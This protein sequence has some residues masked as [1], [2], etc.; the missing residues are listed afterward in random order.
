M[1]PFY[2]F[3]YDVVKGGTYLWEIRK[4]H[5]IYG[6][7]VRINPNEVHINDPEYYHNI[8]AGGTRRV[9]KDPSTIAGF[10]VPDSVGATVDHSL[11]RQR[12]GYMNPY[13]ARRSIVS[14]EPLI[15]ERIMALLRRLDQAHATGTPISLDKAFS[16]MAADIITSHCFGYHY[17]YLG[18]PDLHDPIRKGLKGMSGVF[19]WTRFLPWL[20]RLMKALPVAV[21]RRAQPAAADLLDLRGS[22][23]M[24]LK[25]ILQAKKAGDPTSKSLIIEALGDARIPPEEGSMRRLVDEGQVFILAGTENS[26]RALALGVFYLL[27]NRALLARVR[28]DLASVAD[29]PDEALTLQSLEALPYLALAD[30]FLSSFMNTKTGVVKESIRLSHGPVTRLP[31][32]A[33]EE[34]LQY[35]EYAIP[36]GTPVSQ[37][38]YFVHTNE[39]IFPDPFRF[40]PDRWVRETRRGFPLNNYLASFT[41]GSRQCL[42]MGL[43]Y[44]EIYL[45]FA[46]L[47]RHF[48]MDLVNTTMDDIQIHKAFVIGHP[49]VVK[50]RGAEQGEVKILVTGKR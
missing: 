33:T 21:V 20:S 31:R 22:L 17:D 41:K 30:R 32:V 29:I 11:H 34:T 18:L 14:L 8:Y 19:H 27:E 35:K 26:A 42:G 24:N 37:I 15:H 38:S 49:R 13:F 43:A 6:P 50:G 28:E 47:L 44:A 40:D 23:E 36:P 3:W 1:T 46:R 12:R 9:D 39:D 10:G 7:I 25:R 48:D 5:D 2:D 45:T 4:M 16:A